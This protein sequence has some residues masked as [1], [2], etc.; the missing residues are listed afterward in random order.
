M[1]CRRKLHVALGVD[2]NDHLGKFTYLGGEIEKKYCK[3]K[4]HNG[5]SHICKKTCISE[6][7]AALF[8]TAIQQQKKNPKCSSIENRETNH[9]IFMARNHTQQQK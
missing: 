2:F 3:F 4:N 5:K 6:F 8:L 7:V 9:A 1:P